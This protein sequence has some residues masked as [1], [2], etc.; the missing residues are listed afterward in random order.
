MVAVFFIGWMENVEGQVLTL[1]LGVSHFIQ[2]LD[3]WSDVPPT[4]G[5]ESNRQQQKDGEEFK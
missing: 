3:I 1:S 2:T 4:P 5:N